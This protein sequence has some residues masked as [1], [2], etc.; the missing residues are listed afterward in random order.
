MGEFNLYGAIQP[1]KTR[2]EF[3]RVAALLREA[4]VADVPGSDEFDFRIW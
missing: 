2:A 4:G 3:D 1:D